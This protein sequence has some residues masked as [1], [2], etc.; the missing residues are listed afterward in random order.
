MLQLHIVP[1]E[2]NW[3]IPRIC[4]VDSIP[5]YL[6]P[7]YPLIIKVVIYYGI[8]NKPIFNIPGICTNDS[9]P[10]SSFPKYPWNL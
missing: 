4:T 9:I 10:L 7:K 5:I 6:F 3:N 2:M 1:N 8:P